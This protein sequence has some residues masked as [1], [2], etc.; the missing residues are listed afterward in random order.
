M[1]MYIVENTTLQVESDVCVD[2]Y[3]STSF[4]FIHVDVDI[5]RSIVHYLRHVN[6]KS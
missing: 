1:Y 2:Y 5:Y 6:R 3:I 4:N